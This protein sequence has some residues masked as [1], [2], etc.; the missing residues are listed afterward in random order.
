MQHT[1][2]AGN[3]SVWT[4]MQMTLFCDGSAKVQA[5]HLMVQ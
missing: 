5:E 2:D 3:I 1:A 4:D